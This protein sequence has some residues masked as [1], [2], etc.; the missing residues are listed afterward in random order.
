MNYSS[1]LSFVVWAKIWIDYK[2]REK[3]STAT[4]LVPWPESIVNVISRHN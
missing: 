3:G 4:F 1:S 2:K